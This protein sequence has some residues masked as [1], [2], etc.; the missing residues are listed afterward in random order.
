MNKSLAKAGSAI[1]SAVKN[2][3]AKLG[4]IAD[5]KKEKFIVNIQNSTAPGIIFKWL[6]TNKISVVLF[7]AVLVYAGRFYYMEHEYL[8]ERNRQLITEKNEFLN[9][10]KE[11]KGK[12]L[13][14]QQ[15][16]EKA[17]VDTGKTRDR[18]KDLTSE[19]KRQEILILTDRLKKKR[20]IR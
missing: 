14:L 15:D 9:K 3:A 20:S 1:G 19:Q 2:S 13:K 5:K 8:K 12:V 16:I 4:A 7:I 6:I 11:L 18:A 17:K 10:T